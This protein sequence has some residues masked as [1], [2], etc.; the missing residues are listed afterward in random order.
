MGKFT[1]G[2]AACRCPFNSPAADRVQTRI[3]VNGHRRPRHDPEQ[4]PELV[5]C[6][7]SEHAFLTTL[8]RRELVCHDR[9]VRRRSQRCRYASRELAPGLQCPTWMTQSK[10]ERRCKVQHD[11]LT[12]T[13]LQAA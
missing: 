8:K 10:V 11:R 4:I 1:Y 6:R 12:F 2:N 9:G 7:C 13:E 3:D 5:Q